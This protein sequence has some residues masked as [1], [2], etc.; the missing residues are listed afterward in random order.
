MLRP[1]LFS[2]TKPEKHCG[3]ITTACAGLGAAALRYEQ[4]GSAPR[5]AVMLKVAIAY[6]LLEMIPQYYIDSRI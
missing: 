4:L 2:L 1:S 3:V 5:M 6:G